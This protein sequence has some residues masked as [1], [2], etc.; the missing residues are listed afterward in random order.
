MDSDPTW[1]PT[2]SSGLQWPY[3]SLVVGSPKRI[4]DRRTSRSDA[5][6]LAWAAA[7]PRVNPSPS[8]RTSAWFMGFWSAGSVSAEEAQTAIAPPWLSFWRVSAKLSVNTSWNN[9]FKQVM[10]TT[11]G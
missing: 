2:A 8:L 11:K 5:A 9:P 10:A 7:S 1:G 3:L 4:Q 6:A